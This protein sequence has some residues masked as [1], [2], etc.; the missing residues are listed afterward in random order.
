MLTK[1][2]FI[3]AEMSKMTSEQIDIICKAYE[4]DLT[5]DEVYIF[6]KHEYKAKWMEDIRN[7]IIT[8][9]EHP[10]NAINIEEILKEAQTTNILK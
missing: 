8:N 6:A 2:D 1:E 4:Q 3:K 9:K 10:A 5:D 7:T